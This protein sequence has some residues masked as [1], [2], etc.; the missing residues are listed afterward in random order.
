MSTAWPSL[1]RLRAC[2]SDRGPRVGQ[3]QNW[4]LAQWVWLGWEKRLS[5][6]PRIYYCLSECRNLG[7]LPAS[8]GTSSLASRP[9]KKK[10]GWEQEDRTPSWLRRGRWVGRFL[11]PL[12]LLG[13]PPSVFRIWELPPQMAS[14]YL[15]CS[16]V[17]HLNSRPWIW[18]KGGPAGG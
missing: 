14:L 9:W 8:L 2:R 15:T 13:L 1:D 5:P 7:Q 3:E 16:R 10:K 17:I 6:H 18:G 12:A 4:Q 11:L